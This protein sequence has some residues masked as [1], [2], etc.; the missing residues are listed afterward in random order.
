MSDP[1]RASANVGVVPYLR[2]Q[3][4]CKFGWD[5]PLCEEPT[6][7]RVAAFTGQ[8]Y[9]THRLSNATGTKIEATLRTL[10]PDGLLFCAHLAPTIYMCLYLEDGYSKFQFS[11]GHQ[12][13][14]FSEVELKVNDGF[15]LSVQAR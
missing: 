6:G 1:A 13:M 2:Q 12:T 15:H 5:G 14:L 4:I 9:I 8:S 10:A 11:C 3:C 7:V